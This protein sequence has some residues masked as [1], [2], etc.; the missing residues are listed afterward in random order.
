M[1]GTRRTAWAVLCSAALLAGSVT[2]QLVEEAPKAGLSKEG[3]A[4]AYPLG[5]YWR[6]VGTVPAY[7]QAHRDFLS[8]E[9]PTWC[10]SMNKWPYDVTTQTA[11]AH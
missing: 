9:P 2:A 1:I 8:A 10:R 3:L 11:Q 6:D 4:R 7:W 5:G